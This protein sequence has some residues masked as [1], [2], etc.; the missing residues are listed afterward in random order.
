M[1]DFHVHIGRLARARRYEVYDLTPQQLVA[2]MDREGIEKSVLL[3]LESPEAVAGWFLTEDAIAARDL[4]PERLIAFMSLDPR[5]RRVA[6]MFDMYVE[7]YDCRGFGELKNGLAFDDERHQVIYAKCDEYRL[8]LVFH[9]DPGLC[10]DEV[11]LPRLESMLQ[12]YPRCTF[13]GHGPGFWAAISGDDDR[14]G[15]YPKGPVAPDGVV[16]RLLAEYDN[17]Y[18][19]F[20]A[21]SGHNALTRD[22]DF[23]LGFLERHHEKLL[24]GTDYLRAFQHLPQVDW[25]A[26]VDIPAQWR[27]QMACGNAQRLLDFGDQR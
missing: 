18:A 15:G 11:G 14:S 1:I 3:P 21:G 9:S 8:P 5:S 22:P 17:L 24:F 13:C 19:I 16:D 4:Y 23:T 26:Q 2:R 25:L 27:R 10:Y 7:D 12:R 20:D 6:E